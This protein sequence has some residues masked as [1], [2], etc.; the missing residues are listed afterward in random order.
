[1]QSPEKI[2]SDGKPSFRK[3]RFIW[4]GVS[5]VLTA[6]LAVVFF[7]PTVLAQS[8]SA[9]SDRLLFEFERVFKFIQ[10]NYVDETDPQTLMDGAM[11]GMF[12]SLGDPH[13][14]YLD[15][16]AMRDLT[17]TTS[18][19]FGG[20]GIYISK[21][22]PD[23]ELAKQLGNSFVE[24]VAPIEDTPAF[25]AG[26]TAGDL[27]TKIEGESTEKLSSDEVIQRLRGVPGSD[28][29][30]TIRRG[31]KVTFDVTLKRAMIQVPTVK[32][33]MIPGGIGYVRIIQFTPYTPDNFKTAVADLNKQGYNKLIIDLRSN[34]GGLLT[35]VVDTGDLIFDDGVI[36]STKSRL[37]YENAVYSAHK[38]KVID[39]DVPIVVLVD[40]GSAS[41]AEI[42]AGALKDRGRAVLVGETTYGKGSVQQVHTLGD[43]GFRL[44]MSRYYTPADICIDK[45]G[46]TPDVEVKEPE[47]SEQQQED[48]AALVEQDRMN[49][50][51]ADHP[52]ASAKTVRN[53]VDQLKADGNSLDDRILLRLVRNAQNRT[54]N[55]PPV[56]DLDYDIVLQKAVQMLKTGAV[57]GR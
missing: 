57:T 31:E 55:T 23:S 22:E 42:L 45:I 53:F 34:P 8:K 19:E 12:D 21:P 16:D 3:E 18:G 51:V 54:E 56:Y 52:G 41:A 1:M 49:K 44:T 39:S 35:A 10:Q 36:V 30:V 27:I 40:K 32:H 17:D 13:S 5:V 38:G 48:L 29:V 7:S 15:A 25:H 4:I 20:V 11:K 43:T 6:V 26:L 33:A 9:E 2:N 47:L 50:F 28:V 37:P 14:A 24:V 46:I